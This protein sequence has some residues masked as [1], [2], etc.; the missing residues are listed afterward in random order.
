MSFAIFPGQSHGPP[1]PPTTPKTDLHAGSKQDAHRLVDGSGG[2]APPPGRQNIDF[3]NVDISELSTD[4]IGTIDGFDVHEF[5]QYLPPNSHSSAVLA[6]QDTSHAHNNPTESFVLPGIHS[7]S[8]SSPTW[9]PKTSGGTPTGMPPSS[10]SSDT[11]GPHED[12]R[13]RPQIKTEQ[14]SPGHYSSSSSSTP[15]PPQSEYTAVS[16][17]TCPSSTSSSSSSSAN[18]IEYNDLQSSSFY[19]AFSGYPSSLY[20]YPYF[21]SSRSPYATPLINSLALAPSPHSP[22]SGWEPPI[23]TTLTRP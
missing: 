9:T 17:G 18:L 15:P 10:S 22:P 13:H 8:H 19:S 7:H 2:S 4:V 23:Y 16:S 14:M 11:H 21:H 1:T 3:S 6:L 5:D 20:Q 12:A